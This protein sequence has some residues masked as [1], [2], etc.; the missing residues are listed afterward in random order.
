MELEKI[1][2]LIQLMK[3]YELKEIELKE[4]ESVIKLTSSNLSP[5]TP[6]SSKETD[7]NLTPKVTDSQTPTRPEKEATLQQV[8]SPFVGTFFRASSPTAKCFVEKEH[9]NRNSRS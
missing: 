7:L 8:C 4:K 6:L 2:K 1:E 9:F 5:E 3:R